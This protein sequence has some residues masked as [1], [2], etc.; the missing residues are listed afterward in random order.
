MMN[1]K[2]R[3]AGLVTIVDLCGQIVLGEECFSLGKLVRDLLA[4]GHNKILLNL[5]EVHRIDSAGLAHI[6]SGL[7][8]ARKSSGDLKLLNP[9]KDFH[10]VLRI[11]QMLSVLDIFYDEAAAVKSFVESARAKSAV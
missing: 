8:R 11:T 1:A 7:T 4:Q 2:T 9:T 6:F 10:D 5:A 3:H